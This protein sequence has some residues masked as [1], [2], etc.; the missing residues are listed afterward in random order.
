VES[1][2]IRSPETDGQFAKAQYW[3][4]L[5]A[6][7]RVKSPS[8][9]LVGWRRS[10]DRTRLHAKSLVSGNFTGNFAILGLRD[11]I[12]Y[13]ETAAL[14]P[15]FEQFPTQIIREKISIKREFLGDNRE[16]HL[17]IVKKGKR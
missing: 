11:T 14:Q 16:S 12:K 17:Q 13:Q 9:G 3:W 4:A 10:A 15:L 5:R 2:Q 8:A 1:G 6:L 7:R